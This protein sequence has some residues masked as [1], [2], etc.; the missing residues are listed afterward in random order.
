MPIPL[1]A[2]TPTFP[3]VLVNVIRRGASI[4]MVFATVN[5]RNKARRTL[6]AFGGALSMKQLKLF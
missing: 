2:H 4:T 1:P 6:S 3:C 5:A